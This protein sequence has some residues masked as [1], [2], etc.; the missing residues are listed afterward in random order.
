MKNNTT[1]RGRVSLKTKI[2]RTIWN[3][4]AFFLFRPFVTGL[5]RRWRIMILRL[6][7]AHIHPSANI[8]ASAKIWAPWNLIMEKGTCLGPDVIC[9]NQDIIMLEEGA[10]VSQHCYLCTAS[11]DITKLNRPL[12]TAPITIKRKAWV[13]SDAFIGMGVT[14]GEFSVIGA[15]ACVYKDVEPY[16]VVGGNPAKLLKVRNVNKI[17]GV[18]INTWQ[19]TDQA[20]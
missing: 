4:V 9:Y 20:A 5:F 6:F 8:Y 14:V 17:G 10:I 1:L 11:H 7:G 3:I 12:I 16:T 19:P 2:G 18:R 15:R 13:A